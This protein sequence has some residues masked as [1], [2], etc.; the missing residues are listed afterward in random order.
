MPFEETQNPDTQTSNTDN[1]TSDAAAD[2]DL[3]LDSE[4]D[5]GSEE[6]E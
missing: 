1:H 6:E 5:Q 2:L 3:S 4:E